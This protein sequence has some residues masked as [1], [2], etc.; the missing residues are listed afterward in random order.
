MTCIAG[1]VGVVGEGSTEALRVLTKGAGLEDLASRRYTLER[2]PSGD[3][4][5]GRASEGRRGRE[6]GRE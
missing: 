1:R 4:S 2:M 5:M 3:V 6:G